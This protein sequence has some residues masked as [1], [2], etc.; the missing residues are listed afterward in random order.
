MCKTKFLQLCSFSITMT[1][2]HSLNLP[3]LL[4]SY[5][6]STAIPKFP[7]WFSTSPCWFSAFF[8]FLPRFQTKILE[9]SYSSSKTNTLLCYYRITLGT[10]SLFTS[11]ETS[12]VISPKKNYLKVPKIYTL[13]SII[14]IGWSATQGLCQ[15][16]AQFAPNYKFFM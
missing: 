13:W 16:E 4:L 9:N 15:R 1:S 12:S 2:L 11:S 14:M 7:P 8:S 10:K 6:I 5:F 3:F